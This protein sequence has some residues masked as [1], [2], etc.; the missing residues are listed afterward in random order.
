MG[1][2]REGGSVLLGIEREEEEEEEDESSLPHPSCM[3]HL[4]PVRILRE[5]EKK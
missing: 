3:C 1:G 5:R 4:L 2:E